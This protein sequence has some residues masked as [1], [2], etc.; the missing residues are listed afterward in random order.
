MKS[1]GR[2]SETVAVTFTETETRIKILEKMLSISVLYMLVIVVG[3]KMCGKSI[4]EERE[5]KN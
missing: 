5:T 3:C 1:C 2:W 4:Q